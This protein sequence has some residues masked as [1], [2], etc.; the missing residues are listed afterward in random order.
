LLQILQRIC[1]LPTL[2]CIIIIF[3]YYRM[4]TSISHSDDR[5]SP[6]LK[7]LCFRHQKPSVP[8][9]FCFWVCP[10]VNESVSLFVSKTLCIYQKPTNGISPNFGHICTFGFMDVLIRFGVKGERSRSQQAMTRKTGECS[11]FVTIGANFA[12]IR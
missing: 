3:L 10:S 5:I 11:M 8:E 12:K 9:A 6:A 1:R 7:F 2:S 4:P